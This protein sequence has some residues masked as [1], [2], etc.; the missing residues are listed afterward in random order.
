MCA[1]KSSKEKDVDRLI[2]S[3]YEPIFFVDYM[4]QVTGEI[5]GRAPIVRYFSIAKLN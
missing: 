3:R 5:I 2:F 1:I 4:L